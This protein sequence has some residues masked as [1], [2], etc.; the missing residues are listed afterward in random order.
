MYREA[1]DTPDTGQFVFCS[2]LA[3]L[4]LRCL[5]TAQAVTLWAGY[6]SFYGTEISMKSRKNLDDGEKK[7]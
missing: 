5:R 4:E 7:Q 1:R 3:S 2:S 6:P